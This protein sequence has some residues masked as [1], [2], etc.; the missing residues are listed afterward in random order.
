VTEVAPESD[1]VAGSPHP[2]HADRVVG[3]DAAIAEF[4][5]AAGAQ[6]LHHAWML[7]GPRGIGKAT[8]GW[9]MARW[10]L[11]DGPPDRLQIPPDHPVTRRINALSEPRLHLVRRGVDD[12]GRLKPGI[13]V[14]DIRAFRSFFQL[15]AADGGRRIAIIDAADEMNTAAA[16]ALLK[17]LEEPPQ[18][19]LLL[20][21]AHQPGR[22]LPTIRSRCRELRLSPLS[23]QDMGAVL[24]A[25]GIDEDATALAALSGGSVGEALRLA[26]QDGLQVYRQIVDLFATL[27]RFDRSK[28]RALADAAAPRASAEGDAFDLRITLLDLFLSRLARA[29]L[30]GAPIPEAA[31]GEA[32][33][34]ARL[35]PDADAA[36]VWAGAQAE[37][38]ARAR[39]GRAVNLDPA[40][41]LLDMLVQLAGLAPAHAKA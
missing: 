1:R 21:I 13:G 36:R 37:L 40:A 7:T 16:N 6:R 10:L 5:T 4:L 12:K 28:A 27:P 29:G 35:C 25:H 22:L 18:D 23:P 8:L 20:L 34:M 19:A 11:A 24:Q 2:R 26:G 9:A 41:L 3:H 17:T 14:D 15:S 31:P 38:S 39:A 30:L 32:E 33:L